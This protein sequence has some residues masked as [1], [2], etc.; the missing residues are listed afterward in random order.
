MPKKSSV[1]APRI[2]SLTPSFKPAVY[3]PKAGL[4]AFNEVSPI[5]LAMNEDELATP[6]MNI[7]LAVHGALGV[8]AYY[9]SP[10]VHARFQKL[11]SDEFN[12]AEAD[13]LEK[14]CFAAIFAIEEARAMGALESDALVDPQIAAEAAEIET[15]MQ[16]VCEHLLSEDPEIKKQLDRLRPGQG[17]RD[18]ANDLFGYARIYEQRIDMVKKHPVYYRPDDAKRGTE[19]AGLILQA[20]TEALTS[21]QSRDAYSTYVRA[22][23]LVLRRYEEIRQAGLWMFRKDSQ[24]DQRFPSLYTI[25]RPAGGR[26]RKQTGET[27]APA[28]VTPE[29]PADK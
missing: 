20:L 27:P 24:K 10:A 14:A 17:Y 21:S 2:L 28:P 15:R 13:G 8:D 4:A 26:P 22:W 1:A 12:H 3:D 16:T 7:E 6:Q 25:G 11:P 18:L 5:L 9:R 19:L 23:T 29:A